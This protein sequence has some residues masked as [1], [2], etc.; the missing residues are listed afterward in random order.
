MDEL[1][2]GP[3]SPQD[4]VDQGM[5]RRST[6]VSQQSDGNEHLHVELRDVSFVPF[7]Y[8]QVC[9]ATW[10]AITTEYTRQNRM[11]E[12]Y[13]CT[14]DEY[15]CRFFSQSVATPTAS[16]LSSILT[17]RKFTEAQRMVIVWRSI[18]VEDT[19]VAKREYSDET[20]WFVVERVTNSITDEPC[21][22]SA[23]VRVCTRY[24]PTWNERADAK[25]E[26]VLPLLLSQEPNDPKVGEFTKRILAGTEE[27]IASITE[28]IE[29]ILLD[30]SIASNDTEDIDLV[31]DGLTPAALPP[32]Q[33]G[34]DD[35]TSLPDTM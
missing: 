14:D 13:R 17:M 22:Q 32:L 20:G 2:V 31:L 5:M 1:F 25:R 8:D 28:S 4:A 3:V 27:D 12:T 35:P 18:N 11:I 19:P 33:H 24:V 16:V 10:T 7:A 15:T 34:L 29:N 30:E 26:Q 23:I 9:K 6:V 21:D